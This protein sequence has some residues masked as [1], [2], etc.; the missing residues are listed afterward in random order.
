MRAHA[1]TVA[2]ARAPV[3]PATSCLA[4]LLDP[5]AVPADVEPV[6][7]AR[8]GNYAVSVTWS[9]GHDSSIYTFDDLKQY[10]TLHR[11]SEP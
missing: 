7:I 1:R 6:R 9:D 3:T 4:Q 5:A 8:R 10:S 2:A 11:R